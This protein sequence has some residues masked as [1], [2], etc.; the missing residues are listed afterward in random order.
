MTLFPEFKG[1]SAV[2]TGSSAGIGE[3]V[4][5]ALAEN[6]A[7]VVVNG[8]RNVAAGESVA[9][10]CR[11][12]GGSKSFFIQADVS[13]RPDVDRLFGEALSRL[14]KIDFLINGAGGFEERKRVHLIDDDEWDHI[15]ALNL[16]SVFL[17]TK[18]VIPHM[19]ERKFG[20]I[21]SISSWL[22]RGPNIESSAH[23]VACKAAILGFTRQV[24]RETADSGITVNATAPGVAISPRIK[25]LYTPEVMAAI[26]QSLPMK[27]ISE[28]SEQAGP[29]L[30]FC[31]DAA[32]YIT[33]ATLDVNAGGLMK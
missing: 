12:L 25:R 21:V 24:A 10:K 6:G 5:L 32:N 29:I 1:R 23:Y 7:D 20:R 28:A 11:E 30:F 33:G 9:S 18:T 22:G 3:A 4:A 26:A 19:L 13:K 16:R 17:C 27:R 15:V 8:D 31:S 14:G 2:V